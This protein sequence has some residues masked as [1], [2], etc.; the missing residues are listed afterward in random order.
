MKKS[1]IILFILLLLLVPGIS[2]QAKTVNENIG[3]NGK[4]NDYKDATGQNSSWNGGYGIRVSIITYNKG[5]GKVTKKGH[6]IDFWQTIPDYY[7]YF[8]GQKIGMN[9]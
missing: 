6:A 7:T 9:L 2:V 8:T 3:S 4:E 5:T 1:K